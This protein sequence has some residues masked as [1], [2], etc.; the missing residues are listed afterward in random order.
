MTSSLSEND[1]ITLANYYSRTGQGVGTAA[2]YEDAIAL[3]LCISPKTQETVERELEDMLLTSG[4][5][6][7][8]FA[9]CLILVPHD[10]NEWPYPAYDHEPFRLI[11]MQVSLFVEIGDCGGASDNRSLDMNTLKSFAEHLGRRSG[12]TD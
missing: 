4:R 5:S 2:V 10:L 11:Q 3:Y 8:G 6:D 7:D 12:T 1:A 9:C